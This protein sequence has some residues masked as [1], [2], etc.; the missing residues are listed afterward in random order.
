MTDVEVIESLN[1]SWRALVKQYSCRPDE[2]TRNAL[3]MLAK[4]IDKVEHEVKES[5]K[6]KKE[7]QITIDEWIAALN[8]WKHEAA[9]I[10][11]N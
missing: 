11:D 7:H 10:M 3:N 9:G 1:N 8:D 4:I 6:S 2:S 5:K